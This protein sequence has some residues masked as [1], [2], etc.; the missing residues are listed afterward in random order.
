MIIK[1]RYLIGL[2]FIFTI[3]CSKIDEVVLEFVGGS[4][5][6]KVFVSSKT[7]KGDFSNFNDTDYNL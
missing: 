4:N 3:S 7:T 2:I 5:G 6:G 1:T